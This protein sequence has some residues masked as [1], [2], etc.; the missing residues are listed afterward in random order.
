MVETV[1]HVLKAKFVT[2][3]E[4]PSWCRHPPL[5]VINAVGARTDHVDAHVSHGSGLQPVHYDAVSVTELLTSHE[6]QT[7]AWWPRF[8]T[9]RNKDGV[10]GSY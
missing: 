5:S 10:R 1:Q 3:V 4:H 9:L 6:L 7:A 2:S 8:I